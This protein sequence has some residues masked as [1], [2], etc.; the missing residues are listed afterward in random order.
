M[1]F[2]DIKSEN[3]KVQVIALEQNFASEKDFQNVDEIIKRG[4]VI[5]VEGQFGKSKT[6]EA[7]IMAKKITL[8]SPCLHILPAAKNNEKEV[9]TCQET[10]YRNRYLDLM[11]NQRARDVFIKRSK[12]I[13]L[14]RSELNAK[15]FMEVETPIL[16]LLAGGA[17]AKPFKTFHND[18]N[19]QMVLRIAP[20]LYLKNLIVGGLNKVY[21]IGK[22]FRN[23]QIDLTHNPEFTSIELY[24]AYADYNDMME[25]TEEV[26]CKIVME[27]KGTLKFNVK[28][29]DGQDKEISFE[30]P[31]RRIS[32]VEEL[33]KILN[34]KMPENFEGEEP[35]QFLDKLCEELK[36]PCSA[37]RTTARLFDKLIAEY[38][39]VQCDSP[40]FLIDHP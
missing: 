31:W 14:L 13:S 35:R 4:D 27:I 15:G 18:L 10:R 39:E 16:A 1:I 12:I 38:I 21:E 40:T 8:L 7:S 23:E 11:C 36:I 3:V 30:R 32:V 17:T 25:F 26:L 5:G 6:G 33:E 34:R 24:Q 2:M 9:I 37:P 19:R 22:Q 28:G 29:E 20:E